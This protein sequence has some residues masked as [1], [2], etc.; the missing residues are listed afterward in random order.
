MVNSQTLSLRPDRAHTHTHTHT[1]ISEKEKNKKRGREREKREKET[2]R[3]SDRLTQ[4]R[5]D[6]ETESEPWRPKWV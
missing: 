3:K 6:G 4:I 2:V 1:R 5:E